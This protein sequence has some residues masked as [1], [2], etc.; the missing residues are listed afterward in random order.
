MFACYPPRE[1]NLEDALYAA[2][3]RG[4]EDEEEQGEEEQGEEEQVEEQQEPDAEDFA[5]DDN[6]E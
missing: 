1:G 6:E 3:F 5:R 2:G 4:G